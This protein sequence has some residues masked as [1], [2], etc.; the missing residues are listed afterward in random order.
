MA[1]TVK[2]IPEG[3][4]TV[5]PYLVVKGAADAIDYYKRA[6]GAVERA[7][8][9]GPEGLIMHAEL[10]IGDSLVMLSDETPNMGNRSPKTLGGTTVSVFL[11]VDDVDAVHQRALDAG[12]TQKMAVS[13]MFWGDRFGT[14]VDPFGHEWGIAT[15]VEDVT[16][17]EMGRRAAQAMGQPS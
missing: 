6:F 5:T 13:D 3:Y 12:G 7:R 11:Y 1:G 16:P 14:L 10:Q 15:H 8:M 2:P 9:P 17:E 4:H